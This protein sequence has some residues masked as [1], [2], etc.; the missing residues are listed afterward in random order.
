MAAD[1]V[2][3]VP[4]HRL[5]PSVKLKQAYFP[6]HVQAKWKAPAGAGPKRCMV[7]TESDPLP[8]AALGRF[9]FQNFNPATEKLQ[10]GGAAGGVAGAA[11]GD[12][13]PVKEESVNDTKMASVLGKRLLAAEEGSYKSLR[14]RGK[15]KRNN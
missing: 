6:F 12:A 15:R 3:P 13:P 9:S 7:I 1:Q 2:C 4:L 10:Q 11:G 8:P 5:R 14:D